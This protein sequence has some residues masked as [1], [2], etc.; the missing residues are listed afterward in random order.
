MV[1]PHIMYDLLIIDIH[2]FAHIFKPIIF[3][4]KIHIIYIF[5][6]IFISHASVSCFLSNIRL[7]FTTEGGLLLGHWYGEL[8]GERMGG[9]ARVANARTVLL[10]HFP[11]DT[12]SSVN[13]TQGTK[14]LQTSNNR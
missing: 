10:F 3:V 6:T 5:I 4:L 11:K 7:R 9:A 12:V 1:Q 8:G 13:V 14:I 2:H